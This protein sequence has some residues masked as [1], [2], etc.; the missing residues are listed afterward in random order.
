MKI[1]NTI[2]IIGVL[3]STSVL[4]ADSTTSTTTT[5]TPITPSTIPTNVVLVASFTPVSSTVSNSSSAL[6]IV[7]GL[8]FRNLEFDSTHYKQSISGA[9][10]IT[11]PRGH[12]SESHDHSKH[13]ESQ[14]SSNTLSNNS[15]SA[16]NSNGLTGAQIDE[17]EIVLQFSDA[18]GTAYAECIMQRVHNDDFDH[19]VGVKLAERTPN[20]HGSESI[21]E[22]GPSRS[23]VSRSFATETNAFSYDNATWVYK[24]NYGVCNATLSGTFTSAGLPTPIQGDTVTVYAVDTN[25]SS[26]PTP[27]ATGTLNATTGL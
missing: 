26:T 24:P 20:S 3:A 6:N 22:S 23:G 25:V 1:I 2:G 18:S 5:A 11:P 10:T 12:S 17:S 7:G 9:I 21:I 19:F 13:E 8:V 14:K 15:N 27:I 16:S 4:A